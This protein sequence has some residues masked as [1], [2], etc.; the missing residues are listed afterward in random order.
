MFRADRFKGRHNLNFRISTGVTFLGGYLGAPSNFD[1]WLSDKISGWRSSLEALAPAFAPHPQTAYTGLQKSLQQ[2]WQYCQRVNPCPGDAFAPLE[3]VITTQ[4]LPPLFG[5]QEPPPRDLT[6]LPVKLS[7]L[8]L[9][10]P[11]DTCTSNL[12]VSRE[13][14]KHL[15]QSHLDPA[16]PFNLQDHHDTV[17]QARSSCS[18]EANTRHEIALQTLINACTLPPSGPDVAPEPDLPKQRLLQRAQLTGRFLTVYPSYSTDTALSAQEFRDRLY[19]RY[20]LHPSDLP[21]QCDGCN[22]PFSVDHAMSCKVGGLINAR[23]DEIAHTLGSLYIE[24]TT[25]NSCLL[26]TSDAADE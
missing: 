22:K 25:P 4:L 13:V 1:N 14:T 8:S 9:P 19:Y 10:R 16:S 17:V 7:G 23:H 12:E 15:P 21:T 5:D 20:G 3:E 6:A 2:E 24:A 11:T 26:Y 18:I